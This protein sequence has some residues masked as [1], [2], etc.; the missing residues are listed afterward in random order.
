[1]SGCALIE[2][3]NVSAKLRG[4]VKPCD[5]EL[6]RFAL[7]RW[8]IIAFNIRRTDERYTRL[9]VDEW[10]DGIRSAVKPSDM[11]ERVISAL[12]RCRPDIF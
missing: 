10:I 9:P 12:L 5:T 1:M 6:V 3:N 2:Y 11:R 4:V 8:S 7:N